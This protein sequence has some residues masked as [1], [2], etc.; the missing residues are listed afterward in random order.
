MRAAIR[1][2]ASFRGFVCSAEK[3]PLLYN[4][5]GFCCSRDTFRLL[6]KQIYSRHKPSQSAEYPR[7]KHAD[8]TWLFNAKPAEARAVRSHASSSRQ[9][10]LACRSV[11]VAVS[12]QRSHHALIARS[13]DLGDVA[14][15]SMSGSMSG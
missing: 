8:L 2:L 4:P 12:R 14:V 7:S 15:W 13:S 3:G 9:Q 5:P 6:T 1:R 11:R 10:L